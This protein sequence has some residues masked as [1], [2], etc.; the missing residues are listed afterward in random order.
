MKSNRRANPLQATPR[1]VPGR[2]TYSKMTARR[3]DRIGQL[4]YALGQTRADDDDPF[5]RRSHMTARVGPR[6][7]AL[8]P[9]SRMARPQVIVVTN[10]Q[11]CFSDALLR[12]D[13]EHPIAG[14]FALGSII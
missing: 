6:A 2:R 8:H 1:V 13:R 12:N 5:N 4:N 3:R 14:H 10:A 7:S 9:D 11:S